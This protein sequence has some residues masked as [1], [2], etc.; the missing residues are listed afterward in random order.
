VVKDFWIT[1]ALRVMASTATAEG[2]HR[3][4]ETLIFCV[5]VLVVRKRLTRL[6]VACMR[7]SLIISVCLP[8]LMLEDQLTEGF[9]LRSMRI[10]VSSCWRARLLA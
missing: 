9:D 8:M 10:P 3:F 4:S 6:C 7:R 1:E 5:W 2:I